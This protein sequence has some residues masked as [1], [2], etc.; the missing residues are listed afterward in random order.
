MVVDQGLGSEITPESN[1]AHQEESLLK[2]AGLPTKRKT[3]SLPKLHEYSG[4]AQYLERR[5]REHARKGE[6]VVVF[7][8]W[9]INGSSV[10]IDIAL[11][12]QIP[13]HLITGMTSS[14]ER[15]KAIHDFQA[16]M[17]WDHCKLSV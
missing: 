9:D 12:L 17:V 4:K 14:T 11:G 7:S 1:T 6:P 3:T 10:V 13:F 2:A 8:Q 5:L 16:G 15:Q